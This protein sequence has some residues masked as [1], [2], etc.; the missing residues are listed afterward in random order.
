M[1]GPVLKDQG[2]CPSIHT[3]LQYPTVSLEKG[4]TLK[5]GVTRLIHCCHGDWSWKMDPNEEDEVKALPVH[6]LT[7]WC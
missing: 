1:V 6:I 2:R 4:C 5:V 3:S 7:R